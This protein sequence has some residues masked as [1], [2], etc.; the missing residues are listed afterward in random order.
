MHDSKHFV[1]TRRNVMISIG[2]CE[3]EIIL[4]T[5]HRSMWGSWSDCSNLLTL[6]QGIVYLL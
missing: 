1:R 2:S 3:H 4:Q 6:S 5:Q